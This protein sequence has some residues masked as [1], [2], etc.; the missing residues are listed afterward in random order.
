M[1]PEAGDILPGGIH[2]DEL[3]KILSKCSDSEPCVLVC[4]YVYVWTNMMV[5]MWSVDCA[6]VY[7][8]DGRPN[9]IS[10]VYSLTLLP[11]C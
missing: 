9:F 2:E 10:D 11:D 7:I 1:L 8:W 3:F 6:I 5:V 4:V